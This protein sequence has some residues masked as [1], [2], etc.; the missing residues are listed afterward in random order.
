M[1]SQDAQAQNDQLAAAAMLDDPQLVQLAGDVFVAKFFIYLANFAFA[2]AGNA[3]P[4]QLTQSIQIDSDADF[5]LLYLTGNA[6]GADASDQSGFCQI[7]VF[8]GSAGGLGWQTNPVNW[9]NWVGTG[10]LPFPIGLIPQLL[11]KK[12]TYNIQ[13]I[14]N[15]AQAVSA[16]VCFVGYKLYPASQSMALGAAP[17]QS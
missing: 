13:V 1:N 14:S 16:Q 2:T 4:V 6:T 5:Q 8:E 3:T 15:S 12:R 11:A 9:N 7:S 10:Q 17:S